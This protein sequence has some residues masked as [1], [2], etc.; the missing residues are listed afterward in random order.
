[1]EPEKKQRENIN[2]EVTERGVT[3]FWLLRN[4][5]TTERRMW[6]R[7]RDSESNI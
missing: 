6:R 2:V 4:K 7:F 3:G 1:M 5:S